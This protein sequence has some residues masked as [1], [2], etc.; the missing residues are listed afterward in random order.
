MPNLCATFS[1]QLTCRRVHNMPKKML[2]EQGVVSQLNDD[3]DGQTFS[4]LDE[5]SR[6][7]IS[8]PR[9]TFPQRNAPRQTTIFT[10]NDPPHGIQS[11][12]K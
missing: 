6:L 12:R 3:D 10:V 7:N 8:L 1:R 11:G 5:F 2:L 9:F 4:R